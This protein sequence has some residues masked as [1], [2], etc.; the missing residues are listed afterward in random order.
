M[1]YS[2][3]TDIQAVCSLL[4]LTPSTLSEYLGVAR[5]TISRIIH[6][7]VYPEEL[8]LQRF[9]S[10]VYHN[11]IRPLRLNELK[12]QFAKDEHPYLLF[13]GAKSSLEGSVDLAH[14]RKELD[15]GVGFYLGESF[16]QASS[17]ISPFPKSS[18]YLADGSNL[19]KLKRYEYN[20]D[21]EWMLVVSYYRRRLD[22]FASSPLLRRYIEN[23]A[24]QDVLI[25]PI[26]DNNMYETMNQF[27]RGDITDVQA[28]SAL[29]A[30]SLGKQT[31]LKT[32][33]ACS[34]IQLVD[35]LYL[36][37]DEK[38]DFDAKRKE[39]A[40]TARDKSKLAISRHR[41]EGRYV[42]EILK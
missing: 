15:L 40:E 33:T 1:N 7:K 27:A 26:A 22:A 12:V 28:V 16:A 20:V 24:A 18:V 10:F 34:K 30:S 19:R 32:V 36:C 38:K 25:A 35:R 5:S 11:P 29:S 13:H 8:F 42:E 23:A 39:E 37:E 6:E 3:A 17:Y 21:L 9:Y 2:I 4:G 31:V 41:R 14:S